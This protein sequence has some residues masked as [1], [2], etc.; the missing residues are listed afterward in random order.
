MNVSDDAALAGRLE[1]FAARDVAGLVEATAALFPQ[2]GAR[3]LE[4]GGGIAGYLGAH[5]PANGAVGLGFRGEVTHDQI[6][7]VEAFFL[8]LGEEPIVS[9]C[10]H[11]HPSLLEVLSEKGW[12]PGAYENVLVRPIDPRQTF[13]PPLAGVEVREALDR[14]DLDAWALMAA[15]GFSAPD[16]PTQAEIQLATAATCRDGARFLFGLVDGAY[17]GTGQLEIVDDLAWLSAD[18]TLPRFRRRGVQGSLQRARLG[19][20]RDAGCRL[21]VT[22]S[23]PGSPSQRN[24]ERAGFRVAYTRV[25]ARYPAPPS[26]S[27]SKG[28]FE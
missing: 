21:A 8:D 17:A 16:E 10:P 25:D 7:A 2:T 23:T 28:A 3:S 6:S 15:H 14:G 1:R 19:I 27:P 26:A 18:T 9:V 22:E 13:E 24:M 5:S 4:V 20:A 12:T 11:A